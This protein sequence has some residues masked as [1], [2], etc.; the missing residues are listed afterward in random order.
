MSRKGISVLFVCL[1]NICRSPTADAIAV[2]LKNKFTFIN[3]I[4]SAGTA[5]YHI[6]EP[7]DSRMQQVARDNGIEMSQLRG[8]QVEKQDF[9]EF[10][11]VVAMD[12]DN[13]SNLLKVAPA[14]GTAAVVKLLDYGEQEVENVPDPYYGG[15]D[16]F[17]NCF[18]IIDTGV[19]NFF[20]FLSQKG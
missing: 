13:Y 9:Y 6:N 4:D 18:D 7:P 1:G 20:E 5:S 14:D 15:Y 19:I 17:V 11:Y 12:G 16:G 8:R 10:D 3:R 2:N